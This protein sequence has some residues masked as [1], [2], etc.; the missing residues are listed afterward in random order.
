MAYT[1]WTNTTLSVH[2]Q[3]AMA[4]AYEVTGGTPAEMLATTQM[5]GIDV[6]NA[7]AWKFRRTT[8]ATAPYEYYS[9]DP[10]TEGL[11][12]TTAPTWPA[13]FFVGWFLKASAEAH[14]R[15]GT[16][17]DIQQDYEAQYQNWLT[18]TFA[19][20]ETQGESETIEDAPLDTPNDMANGIIDM[21][22]LPDGGKT[23]ATVRAIT[24]AA[25]DTVFYAYKWKFRRTETEAPGFYNY[26][27]FTSA[28]DDETPE[29]PAGILAGWYKQASAMVAAR[30]APEKAAGLQAEYDSWFKYQV[31]QDSIPDATE[32]F[33]DVPVNTID[34]LTTSMINTNGI[35]DDQRKIQA[36]REIV[37]QAGVMLWNQLDWKFR[38]RKTTLTTADGTADYAT[39]ADFAKLDQRWIRNT[40]QNNQYY[41]TR[42]TDDP[43]LF[44]EIS[45]SYDSTETGLPVSAFVNQDTTALVFKWQI[46]VIPVPDKA[47]EFV[48][49][50]LAQ[51]P[52]SQGLT[53]AEAPL[54]P[55]TFNNGWRLLSQLQVSISF[56]SDSASQDRRTF[57]SWLKNQI[58]EN[59]ETITDPD[60]E[61]IIDGYGDSG[62]VSAGNRFNAGYNEWR[63]PG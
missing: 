47:Y 22:G 32:T 24:R 11:D 55:D 4:N 59:N 36:I 7:R 13:K 60:R 5:A 19:I 49:W 39:P 17:N 9:T 41:S 23:F 26:S 3:T 18:S 21:L 20:D 63:L 44:Q 62:I 48:Y 45:D 50:Y 42:F 1:P 16:K 43:R 15:F 40:T 52:W 30:M 35:D 56:K 6:W 46:S 38:V 27:D 28:G 12:D 54:W 25:S 37:K 33:T 8:Q 51:D 2:I 10:W 29:W 31:E 58:D 53:A 14:A 61:T 57:N 34:A